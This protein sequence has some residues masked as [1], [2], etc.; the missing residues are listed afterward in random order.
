[1]P[2]AIVV[3]DSRAVRLILARTLRDLGFEVEEA[4][5]GL[6]AL[7]LLDQDRT[8]F[9]LALLDWNMPQMNGLELL[10]RL[11]SNNRFSTL[12]VMM[13]TTETEMDHMAAAMNAGAN[14]YVMKPFTRDILVD[15]LRMIGFGSQGD[16]CLGRP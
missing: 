3:D 2:K 8:G 4:G 1:L 15:K 6:K 7:E 12:P 16:L 13:V 9:S 11:R 14:E 10:Q 5:D